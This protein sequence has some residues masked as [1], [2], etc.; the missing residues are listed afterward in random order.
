MIGIGIGISPGLNGAGG[1]VDVTATG[2]LLVDFTVQP[3]TAT[4]VTY[5][6]SGQMVTNDG[7]FGNYTA[8][9]NVIAHDSALTGATTTKISDGWRFTNTA[10]TAP[11][12]AKDFRPAI[13]FSPALDFTNVESLVFEWGFPVAADTCQGLCVGLRPRVMDSTAYYYPTYSIFTQQDVHKSEKLMTRIPCGAL[14]SSGWLSSGVPNW[15]HVTQIQPRIDVIYTNGGTEVVLRR[16]WVNRKQ[17]RAKVAFTFDDSLKNTLTTAVPILS[18]VGAKGGMSAISSLSNTADPDYSYDPRFLTEAE[19]QEL[20]ATHGWSIYNHMRTSS[21]VL[22]AAITFNSYIAGSPNVVRFTATAAVISALNTWFTTGGKVLGTDT[23]TIR[24]GWGPEY[25]G[26]HV[27]NAINTSSNYFDVQSGP[28][29]LTNPLALG[30]FRMDYPPESQEDRVANEI[31]PCATYLESILGAGWRGAGIFVV[32]QG[33]YDPSYIPELQ[34]AGFVGARS[35]SRYYT[36]SP[37]QTAVAPLKTTTST[38]SGTPCAVGW[39]DQWNICVVGLDGVAYA[40]VNDYKALI[41]DAVAHGHFVCFLSH[42][43]VAGTTPNGLTTSSELLTDLA[44][45]CKTHK[46]AGGLEFVTLEQIVEAFA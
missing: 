39:F 6:A 28:G 10:S 23:V 41:D 46:D 5:G 31:V 14:A 4:A 3:I 2:T 36:G 13:T 42:N 11:G 27:V 1:G 37:T 22:A 30:R 7:A 43:V 9:A 16:I 40:N 12:S 44:N 38:V 21:R 8:T 19:V 20:Y 26:A 33:D 32:P 24:G 35:T 17:S 18:A 29:Y 45:Y 25:T 34:A 15:N